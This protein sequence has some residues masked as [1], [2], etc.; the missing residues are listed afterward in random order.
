MCN[1]GWGGYMC[2]T[3]ISS[4]SPSPGGGGG[5]GGAAAASSGAL[6]PGAAFGVS[7]LVIVGVAGALALFPSWGISLMGKTF[8]PGALVRA[9]GAAA[10]NAAAGAVGK[11]RAMAGSGPAE[12][13]SLLKKGAPSGGGGGGGGLSPRAALSTTDAAS[14]LK[15]ASAG[16]RVPT[17]FS[18]SGGTAPALGGAGAYGGVSSE[19]YG[20]L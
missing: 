5:G 2:N 1:D 8:F 3:P 13:T 18:A 9:G 16:S 19:A 15:G 11:A 17:V 20:N 14:R 12:S 10:Y 7:L 6:S 4:P